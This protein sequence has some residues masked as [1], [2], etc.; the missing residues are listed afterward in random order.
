MQMGKGISQCTQL[1]SLSQMPLSR[2]IPGGRAHLT[3]QNME[4]V[5]R[6]MGWADTKD[7][8]QVCY[9]FIFK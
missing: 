4:S 8:A 1:A 2:A 6:Y 9:Q 3:G 5:G 7:L